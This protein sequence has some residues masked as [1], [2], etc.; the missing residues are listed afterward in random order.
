MTLQI[1]V[2]SSGDSEASKQLL[3]MNNSSNPNHTTTATPSSSSS[4]SSPCPLWSSNQPWSSALATPLTP[5]HLPD[6]Y[7]GQSPLPTP[8]SASFDGI[9][10]GQPP[11]PQGQFSYGEAP[12]S[13]LFEPRI[14]LDYTPPT[15]DPLPSPT[16]PS[17]ST[18]NKLLDSPQT[19]EQ[20]AQHPSKKPANARR[21]AQ[22]RAAQRA[23][24]QR[25]DRYIKDL[26]QKA[27]EMDSLRLAIES[28]HRENRGLVE[29]VR[30]MQAELGMLKE[31]VLGRETSAPS[32]AGAGEWDGAWDGAW[33]G[34]SV[35]TGWKRQRVER[36]SL[37]A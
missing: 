22:N 29:M 24:R 18:P 37:Y 20:S 3:R 13:S 25:K 6:M 33:D 1:S 9:L 26:E 12:W 7:M 4:S 2:L 8:V 30:G 16:T 28:L 36:H 11:A 27:R 15:A 32:S 34:V 5:M 19:P 35:G 23:F 10:E 14:S 17:P 21:A 31:R